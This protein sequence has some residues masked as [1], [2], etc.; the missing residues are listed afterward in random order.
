MAPSRSNDKQAREARERLRLY[1]ARQAVNEQRSKRRRRDNIVAIA[2]SFAVVVLAVVAQVAF[3]TTGP[4]APEPSPTTSPSAAA[5]SVVPSPELAENRTWTGTLTL[6]DVELGIELDGAAA[7]QAV[8]AFV[9]GVQEGYYPEKSCHRLTDGG[10]YVL[11]CGSV[12]GTGASDPSFQFGPI[13]NAPA[14][15]LYTA[16]T[17]A[18]A[19][20]S[21]DAESNGRQ[22]FIV[23]EDTTIPS[24]AAGGYTV[25]GRITSGLETLKSEI[26]DAGVVPGS[27][28][29]DGAPVVAT[30]IT[31]VT[32]D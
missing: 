7:P 1:Q 11:Q 6:N 16:G 12:D 10:F 17:I 25:L 4:G 22:F 20:A 3:F 32:L 14:G 23:Y 21:G 15:D 30:T 31:G 27:S 24:D 18:M 29:N 26:T 2:A 9:Q 8:A 13:E 19:R 28:E 5:E